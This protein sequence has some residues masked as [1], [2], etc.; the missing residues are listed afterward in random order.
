MAKQQARQPHAAQ[1][2]TGSPR[3]RILRVAI[4]LGDNVVEERLFRT[5]ETV[6][7]GQSSKNTF[8]IPAAELPK[9]LPLFTIAGDKYSLNLP[10]GADVRLSD[11]GPVLALSQLKDK[12]LASRQGDRWAVPLTNQM[13]GKIVLSD[14]VKILF[15]F[16]IAPPLQPKAQL[17]QSV[18]GRLLDRVD[19]YLAAILLFSL[20]LHGG[21]IGYFWSQDPPREP[22]ADETPERFH[23]DTIAKLEPPVATK[24][25]DTGASTEPVK[26]EKGE[27]KPIRTEPAKPAGGGGGGDDEAKKQQQ[28]AAAAGALA[29]LGQR[30][31][32]AGRFND[33][34]DGRN[35]G[36][37]LE[38]A[39]D[40]ARREG[41]GLSA[42]GGPSGGTRGGATGTVGGGHGPG[43]AGPG[44]GANG[45]GKGVKVGEEA[46]HG[47]S[48]VGKPQV[49]D[50]GG[51]D[52]NTVYQKIKSAYAGRVQKC[53]DDALKSNTALKGRV[54]V[55]IT[56][57]PGGNVTSADVSG[58]DDGVSA[59]IQALARTWRFNKPPNG[60][61]TFQFPFSFRKQG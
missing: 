59:C 42:N 5:R 13:R 52:A 12:G 51:L 58:F 50:D 27:P 18:R 56:I 23:R 14:E 25:A 47:I 31:Q 57:G 29:M 53:Y 40:R 33:V 44:E 54:D 9:S 10:E 1:T 17:P 46:V 24:P 35:P 34:T 38:A 36:G 49:D 21:A 16:V 22:E 41:T 37:D 55:T 6:T 32:G 61:A 11:G 8:A 30:G 45:G 48:T 15:Q 20:I 43:V 3:E 7:I 2:S 60:S 39:V 4:I 19:P 28:G 26:E